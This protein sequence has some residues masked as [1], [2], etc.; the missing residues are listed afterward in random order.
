M[1][2][3]TKQAWCLLGLLC[4]LSLFADIVHVF[5]RTSTGELISD[6]TLDT[7]R[8][9]TTTPAPK[10]SGYIFTHWSISTSQSFSPRD[11]WGR[12]YDSAPFALYE[13]TTLTA[14]YL[15]AS[16][17]TDSDG[18]ADGHELYWYGNLSKNSASDTD[19]DG[20]TFVE[21]LAASTNPLMA[22][23]HDEGPVTFADS[24]EWLYNPNGYQPYTIRSEPEGALFAT[25]T[26]YVR[27][28]TQVTTGTKGTEFAY[29]MWRVGDNAPYQTMR[30]AWGRAVDSVSMAMPSNAIEIVAVAENDYN[31]RM[32]LYWYGNATT[33]M[34]SD[35]DGDGRTFAEELAAGTNPL[36]AE[37]HEEGPV[38][39][40]DTSLW[41][42]NPYNLQP[43]T[44]RSEPEG[45]LFATVTAYVRPGTQVTTGTKGTEFA[46]WMRRVGDN[47]PYQVMRDAW[48]RAL[49]A[50][51][52][53]MPEEKVE[54]VAVA[55]SDYNKR[56]SLYW[57][58][59]TTTAMSSDTDGDGRTFAEELAAG[60]NPLMAERHEDGPVTFAD[61]AEHEMNLQPYEQVQG[62]V[63]DGAYEQLFTSPVAG[64]GAVSATFGDG[65]QIWPVIADV[66]GDGK[67]DIVVCWEKESGGVKS[68]E[69]RVYLNVGSSGNPEFVAARG[70]TIPPSV[71]LAMNSTAK[72][73]ELTLDVEPINAL[74]ATTNGATLLVSDTEGRIWFYEGSGVSSQEL[75]DSN[76][77]LQTLNYQL[78]HKVWGGS[79]A[80]FANGLMLAAVDWEDDG[81]LDCICGTAEGKLML[82]RNPKVGRP[83]NLKALAG[84]DNVLLT[85]DPNQ[86][87]RI[88]GY[89]VYRKEG[90]QGTEETQGTTTDGYVAL[91]PGVPDVSSMYTTALP[92]YRD[93]PNS[94]TPNFSY[95]VSSISRFYTAGNSAPTI[96]ESPATE[97]VCAELG[98]VKFFWNDVVCKLGE[99]ANVMLSIENSMNFNV[100]GK[101]LT[102][103]YDP[104]YLRP[105]KI[106][107]TGLTEECEIEETKGTEGTGTKGTGEWRITFKGGT[108]PAGGG[109]FLTLVF[110]TLKEGETTVGGGL[111]ETSL[112]DAGGEI[113]IPEN[114]GSLG[115]ASSTTGSATVT[116]AAADPEN[117]T[118]VPPY[119]LGDVNGD[120]KLDKEDVRELARL[121][122]GNGRKPTSNQLKAGDFNGNGKL[123]DADYQAL[124]E[125]LKEKGL[126]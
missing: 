82:L 116:I 77:K 110:E 66:N 46:Y 113:D 12:A 105:L 25:E 72:L 39:F 91:V 68:L 52:M 2:K 38:T 122:N 90:T 45:A 47:A 32:S 99:N 49:D 84:V 41:Q 11:A 59:N 92:R 65:S 3:V 97:A 13:E 107:K 51:S 48:G 120:G 103:S 124:R 34:T 79:H 101:T 117:P 55:E 74:S 17:D 100:A 29:W 78:Q 33:P 87:S 7:G 88:R 89:K 10:K 36:M 94:S 112:P 54:F 30:D 125:L 109:K 64:N 4:P 26:A 61:T 73:S 24:G 96:T 115:T 108:L 75:G 69:F 14:H 37:R 15:P 126:L 19:G 40:V 57:Y 6:R 23:R 5:E 44:I 106:A 43:Y 28:G 85:W 1:T 42:Y 21:E 56:M 63:V 86:Q 121:K 8:S 118:D 76:S 123:D 81:D 27:P 83:T 98:T 62:A 22:E 60:T 35:T 9:Y 58:G 102:V 53:A 31:K 71:D 119:S 114:G 80:G 111:G 18:I 70:I 104:E 16:Q 95:K 20:R 50:V 67:W 93:F